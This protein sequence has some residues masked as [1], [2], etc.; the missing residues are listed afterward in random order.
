MWLTFQGLACILSIFFE[1]CKKFLKKYKSIKIKAAG[2]ER[3]KT[4]HR[5]LVRLST[6]PLTY[7]HLNSEMSVKFLDCS[8][9]SLDRILQSFQSV[10]F[11]GRGRRDD[12]KNSHFISPF[13]SSNPFPTHRTMA[14]QLD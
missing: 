9:D 10:S 2:I 7:R 13:S 4:V 1:I 12:Y 6:R 3:G 14:E 8:F 5:Q 11:L